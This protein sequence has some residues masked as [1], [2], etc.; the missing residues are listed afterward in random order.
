MS[1]GFVYDLFGFLSYLFVFQQ[2]VHTSY[3]LAVLR[4]G[5]LVVN[6]FFIFSCSLMVLWYLKDVTCSS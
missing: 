1:A 2:A 6:L 5:N 3:I 4:L